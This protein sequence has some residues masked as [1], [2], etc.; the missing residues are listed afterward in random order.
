MAAVRD[1]MVLVMGLLL[2]GLGVIA[3]EVELARWR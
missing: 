1:A 3:A 2:A